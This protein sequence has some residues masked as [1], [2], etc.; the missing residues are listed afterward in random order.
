MTT[1]AT[2]LKNLNTTEQAPTM[3]IG[4][5]VADAVRSGTSVTDLK[6]ELAAI[7]VRREAAGNEP[8]IIPAGVGLL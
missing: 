4:W 2:E 5:A 8:C 6:A 1:I 3:V 7:N